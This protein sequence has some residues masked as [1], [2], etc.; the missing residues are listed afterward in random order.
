MKTLYLECAM[1]AAG[2]MLMAALLE[3]TD[4]PEEV[5]KDLNSLGLEGV[6]VKA[7]KAVKCGITGTGVRVFIGGHEEESEDVEIAQSCDAGHAHE[8]GGHHHHHEEGC[9]GHHHTHD[10]YAHSHSHDDHAHSHTHDDHAHSH[11]RGGH[12]HEEAHVHQSH[13][14]LEHVVDTIQAL[15]LPQRVKDDAAAVYSR[16][17]KAEAKAHGCEVPQVHF[18]EVGEKDAMMDIVGVCLLMNRLAPDE[19]V[20]SPVHVGSGFVRCAHG[21]LPVPAPATAYLLQGMPVYSGKIR[22]ELCTPTGAALLGHFAD[23]FGPMPQMTLEKTGYGMGKKE[24][25]AANCVRAFLGEAWKEGPA[26]NGQVAE[27]CCNIDDMT[28]EALA[29]ACGLL[30]REGARDV[31]TAPVY[32]KKGRPG[33]LLTCVCSSEQAGHFA[34]LM[35]KHTTTFG[36]RK[37]ICSRYILQREISGVETQDGS[38]RIKTGRGYGLTKEKAEYEDVAAVA[39]KTGKT[40]AEVEKS[41]QAARIAER[42]EK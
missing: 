8:C 6:Q 29:F 4:N 12:T 30:L 5:L 18:H 28:G 25:E 40:L 36:V 33:T 13:S 10:D 14:T 39:E 37:T 19:V 35:L 16:L 3:L 27:L 21:V 11:T 1:G 42:K 31:F 34:A 23:R 24:F 26:P 7:E 32:M 9:C 22:G 17:A 38:V 15:P 41:I 2:D 20:V